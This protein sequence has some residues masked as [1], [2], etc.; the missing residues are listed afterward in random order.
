MSK[1]GRNGKPRNLPAQPRQE[2][3]KVTT[4]VSA[5]MTWQGQMPHPAD[6]AK[7]EETLPGAAERIFTAF[8]TQA[9]HRM[10]LE[11]KVLDANIAH[12]GRALNRGTLILM[13]VIV[14]SVIIAFLGQP[15]VGFTGAMATMVVVVFN[16]IW[17]TRSAERE[18]IE[19][20][21]RARALLTR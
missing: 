15:I 18:R 12:Q 8:E 14:A 7:Y 19:K 20:D 10:A 6:I 21:E 9:A 13:S 2:A 1:P 17:A 16:N 4:T 3:K 11:T 5:S